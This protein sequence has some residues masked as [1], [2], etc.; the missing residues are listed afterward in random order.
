MHLY[1][2]MWRKPSCCTTQH[3][4]YFLNAKLFGAERGVW[5]FKRRS[6]LLKAF[7]VGEQAS[8][9]T[10]DAYSQWNYRTDNQNPQ[11]LLVKLVGDVTVWWCQ[12]TDEAENADNNVNC[13]FINSQNAL[14]GNCPAWSGYSPKLS[15]DVRYCGTNTMVNFSSALLLITIRLQVVLF[16]KVHPCGFV[17]VVLLLILACK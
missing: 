15:C 6:A 7:P 2:C 14:C 11:L 4:V 5:T 3:L 17:S 9:S 10:G 12:E 13:G 8:L 1:P 16:G